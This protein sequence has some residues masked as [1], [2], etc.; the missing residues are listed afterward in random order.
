M[1]TTKK[2]SYC[3]EVY[4]VFTAV[5]GA[6]VGCCTLLRL[7]KICCTLKSLWSRVV[8]YKCGCWERDGGSFKSQEDR[9]AYTMMAVTREGR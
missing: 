4:V 7:K 8:G 2:K 6:C 9:Y 1:R 3:V 5:S